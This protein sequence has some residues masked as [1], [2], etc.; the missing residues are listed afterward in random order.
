MLYAKHRSYLAAAKSWKIRNMIAGYVL[1]RLTFQQHWRPKASDHH[2]PAFEV[3][4]KI[5]ASLQQVKD[6]HHL[7]YRRAADSTNGHNGRNE[8]HKLVPGFAETAFINH[9]GLLFHKAMVGK[10]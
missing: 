6:D 4:K 1:A 5:C 8:R 3:F 10:E 2:V 9:V 7:I